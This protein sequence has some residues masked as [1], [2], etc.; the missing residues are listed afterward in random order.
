M[1]SSTVCSAQEQVWS[2]LNQIS[3]SKKL[4]SAYLFSGPPGCGKEGIAIQF[5]KLLNCE[6]G[7]KDIF[8]TWDYR[9]SGVIYI[10]NQP[11]NLES[12]Y[13]NDLT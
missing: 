12:S 11:Q 9:N 8:H 13:Q 10:Q 3:L 4:G 2:Q 6:L 1:N 5:A 7:G